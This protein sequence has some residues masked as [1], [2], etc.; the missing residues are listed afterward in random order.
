MSASAQYPS[1]PSFPC[2]CP[3]ISVPLNSSKM[4]GERDQI[5][6]GSALLNPWHL[7]LLKPGAH[8]CCVLCALQAQEHHK[9]LLVR[10]SE[11]LGRVSHFESISVPAEAVDARVILSLIFCADLDS[12]SLQPMTSLTASYLSCNRSHEGRGYV[13]HNGCLSSH[14][15]AHHKACHG[16]TP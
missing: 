14:K 8:L 15:M 12:T 11:G 2:L 16:G 7:P 4:F 3:Q 1:F 10:G 6:C 9:Q 5:C 13:A